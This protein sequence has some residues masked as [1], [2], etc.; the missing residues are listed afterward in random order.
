MTQVVARQG[1][2]RECRNY[3]LLRNLQAFFSGEML[4]FKL[5]GAEHA[6]LI[7]ANVRLL[8]V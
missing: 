2:E 7:A 8:I 1:R 4:R 5:T 6:E 3:L